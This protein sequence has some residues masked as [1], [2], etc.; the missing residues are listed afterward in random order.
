MEFTIYAFFITG[1][2]GG[3]FYFILFIDIPNWGE[4]VTGWYNVGINGTKDE[5]TGD[6]RIWP[7]NIAGF[8]GREDYITTANFT[9]VVGN[10]ICA[11]FMEIAK[12]M[13]KFSDDNINLAA[14]GMGMPTGD[15]SATVEDGPIPF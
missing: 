3:P 13:G 14:K 11:K 6:V 1:C 5:L 12:S 10:L 8:Q 15:A 7:S 9:S 2:I 4:M